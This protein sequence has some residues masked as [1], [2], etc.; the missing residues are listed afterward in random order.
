MDRERQLAT[1]RYW[2]DVE[3]LT[4]PDAG[5]EE[6]ERYQA[7][8]HVL[9][10]RLPWLDRGAAP[11][12]VGAPPPRFHYVRFGVMRRRAYEDAL[13]A[14]LDARADAFID[15]GRKQ[16]FGPLTY[17]GVF[18]VED[19]GRGL[20]FDP[21][22]HLAAFGPSF[23]VLRGCD[24]EGYAQA[25]ARRFGELRDAVLA[26]P[27]RRV[28]LG[29]VR[30][31]SDEAVR[32]LDWPV[33]LDGA[34]H[35][36]VLSK[37][38]QDDEGRPRDHRLEPVN[39][40]FLDQLAEAEAAVRAGRSC[41]LV[42]ALLKRPDPT[43]RSDC[44]DA[45]AMARAL[46]SERLPAGRWPAAFPLTLMQQ[47]AVNEAM[48]RLAEG[49][50]V[51]VNGPPG[52]GKTTLLQ[53]IVAA[54]LVQRA[55]E[56]AAFAMPAAAFGEPVDPDGHFP[57]RFRA[58]PVVVAS[59]NNG[60]VENVTRELPDLRKVAPEFRADVERFLPTA[61]ALLS[62][63]RGA[64]AAAPGTVPAGW[65]EEELSSDD[66]EDLQAPEGAAWGLISAPLGAR[67]KRSAFCRVLRQ[68]VPDPDD[69]ETQIDGPANI[70]RQLHHM[71]RIP[72]QRTCD[73]FRGA[74][75]E[76]ERLKAELDRREHLV[77]DLPS[78]EERAAQAEQ[79]HAD[80]EIAAEDAC[81][82]AVSAEGRLEAT[83]IILRSLDEDLS[84]LRRGISVSL[85]ARLGSASAK[86]DVARR[87][88]LDE[89]RQA[90]SDHLRDALGS[91]DE[92]RTA[93]NA[94]ERF[95]RATT[96]DTEA[97]RRTW[98]QARAVVAAIET[99][100][101]QVHGLAETIALP[102]ERRHQLLPGSSDALDRARAVAFVKALRVHQAL[103]S[104]AR[105]AVRKNLSLALTMIAGKLSPSPA[106]ALELWGTLALVVPVL[107]S[108]FSSFKR[109]FD[110]VPAGGL[111][112]LIIDEAGQAVPQHA[113]GAL[114]RA[115]RALVVGDPLQVEPVI[116]LDRS[117]DERL[118]R[119]WDASAEHLSTA[120]SLQ[121][122]ADANN[123][124]GTW[125][126]S[127]EGRVWVGSPLIVHRRCVEPMVSIS[128]D[129]AYADAMV[130]GDG[131]R[132]QEAALSIASPL[133]G[134]SCW[135]HLPTE[136]GGEGHHMAAHAAM[137]A[138]IVRTFVTAGL[139]PRRDIAG[140][141]DLYAIS[142]FRSA[143]HGLEEL[144]E[145]EFPSWGVRRKGAFERWLAK[146]VGTV[147]TVQGKEAEAVVLLLGGRTQGAIA[148]AAGTPN[149]LNVAVTRARRRLYV[150]GDR[151]AWT[152]AP[153]VA[154]CMGEA[155]LPTVSAAQM[156]AALARFTAQDEPSLFG[157][158]VP[159]RRSPP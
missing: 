89:R 102:Y 65:T 33:R 143:R 157:P 48:S 14:A 71:P 149:V 15:G 82:R 139:A 88:E 61:Q 46:A 147:H 96:A 91:L 148:W 2:M 78:Q 144:L 23:A 5:K 87:R 28:D 113:V 50:M 76:V 131:K 55:A 155:R 107:S 132:E 79:A 159:R 151:A 84:H 109:C 40:F 145:R 136:E 17:L 130:L 92:A 16:V 19:D 146:S 153:R 60:A 135:I 29:F 125:I 41:G 64:H 25:M 57:L 133:L 36:V 45:A 115:R 137:A 127:D 6:R 116:T 117:V 128:N 58:S 106:V 47:V 114:M 68:K 99:A 83:R 95:A 126:T 118:L 98:D 20:A 142:P 37:A 51:S 122:M 119:R 86:R 101:G 129:L 27:E 93:R 39:G 49:G 90:A 97:A 70:F 123:S 94:A 53:D 3:G 108:T 120:T 42:P 103:I 81:R 67:D 43:D 66:D 26:D 12:A 85:L 74:L 18:A 124:V 104:G 4:A 59:S 112:W 11:G 80:A 30:A 22:E 77:H 152:R 52:T 121:V 63:R 134:T 158:G 9:D 31:L 38:T 10:E 156:H 75:A 141:P 105:G 62:R 110:T 69:P 35:A 7:C 72:W 138:A 1:L 32:L 44:L 100:H 56:L 24:V 34:V 21:L 154:A 8:V 140:M 111:D 73:E 54:V 13:R 150:V